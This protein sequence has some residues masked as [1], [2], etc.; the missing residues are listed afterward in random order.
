MNEIEVLNPAVSEAIDA[1]GGDSAVAK[2]A[3]IT[4]WA[5]SKWRKNL[6]PDR[7]LWLSELTG[8]TYTPHRLSPRLYPNP[9]D[10]MPKSK[11]VLAAAAK[12]FEAK[13]A[14]SNRP[15]PTAQVSA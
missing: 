2:V 10:G 8:W 3:G 12:N 11:R 14:L 5:V 15:T 1:Y 9:D 6:P 4:A 7:V 13:L